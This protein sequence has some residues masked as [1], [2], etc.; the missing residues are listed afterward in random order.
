MLAFD[1]INLE[2]HRALHQNAVKVYLRDSHCPELSLSA[3]SPTAC[4]LSKLNRQIPELK[5][6][7]TYRKQTA[8]TCSNRQKFQKCSHLFSKC[9][10]SSWAPDL[11]TSATRKMGPPPRENEAFLQSAHTISTRFWSKSR[12]CRK[13]TTKPFL[14]GATTACSETAFRSIFRISAVALGDQFMLCSEA[15]ERP[16]Q[17]SN[18]ARPYG[19]S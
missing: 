16:S 9:T 1:V 15:P 19:R 6:R 7:V 4:K 12:S 5:H 2:Q 3:W 13:Q 8:E 14:P 11:D 10:G 18:L 17:S